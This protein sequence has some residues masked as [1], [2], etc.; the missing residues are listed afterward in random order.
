MTDWTDFTGRLER[1]SV[2]EKAV[3]EKAFTMGNKAHEGQQRQSGEPYFSHPIAVA[4]ILIDMGADRDTIVAALLHDTV[5]DTP[6]TLKDIERAFGSDVAVLID[7][8][9]KLEQTDLPADRQASGKPKLDEQIE[10]LRKMFTL[11]QQDVR[12][13]VIKLADRLHN[14][15][16]IGFRPL[17]KQMTVARE[18]MDIY[19]KIA[20]RLGMRDMQD[21]L[22]SL[23]LAVLEPEL[24]ARLQELRHARQEQGQ[25]SLHAVD[26]QLRANHP[27]ITKNV[28]VLYEHKTWSRLRQQLE[29]NGMYVTGLA[30]VAAAIVCDTEDTCY[31]MMG[32]LHHDWQRETL[33]FQDFI[34]SPMING[35]R[36]LHT[37]IITEDGIR[38][39]CKIRTRDMQEYAHRGITM[40]CFDQKPQ[41]PMEYLPWTQRI[42]TIST[43]TSDR[44]AEFWEGL[45]SDIL[46]E[47]ILVHGPNDSTVLVPRDATVLDGA[48]FLLREHAHTLSHIR[49]N[50]RDVTFATPL[51]HAAT[52]EIE[53]T[54]RQAVQH[55]WLHIVKTGLAAALIRRGLSLQ[56]REQKI[57]VGSDLLEDHL[58]DTRRVF[59]EE[60]QSETVN[61]LLK[62]SDLPPLEETAILIAEGR[63]TPEEVSDRLFNRNSSPAAVRARSIRSVVTC[64]IRRMDRNTLLGMLESYMVEHTHLQTKHDGDTIHCRFTVRLNET[65]RRTLK[66][67]FEN[68]LH[69]PYTIRSVKSP[70]IMTT[71]TILLFL[72]WGLD[73]VFAHILLR[74]PTLSAIDLHA[75]RFLS[76]TVLS[77][78]GLLYQHRRQIIPEARLPLRSASLWISVAFLMLVS[79]TSY[80]SL[81]TTSPSHYT[82]PMTAA[83]LL[84]TSIV[85]RRHIATLAGVWTTFIAGIALLLMFSPSW[86]G[87]DMFWTALAVISFAGFS[88]VS[89]RYK[90][91]EHVSLRVSQYFFILSALCLALSAPLLFFS[92]L[93]DINAQTLGLSILFCILCTALPY[94]IYYSLLS[95]REIDFVLRFS[96][97]IIPLTILCQALLTSV[98][99]W[100]T[101][102]AALIVMAGAALPPLAFTQREKLTPPIANAMAQ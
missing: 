9:T 14:M 66:G 95:H 87:M 56:E 92:T 48:Y 99:S 23:C 27:E 90:R 98:P 20:D 46:G 50:G 63:I 21:T 67:F 100:T 35:Y 26:L 68:V 74:D 10:T 37:T 102:I 30:T 15:Q 89:E 62:A 86:V 41:G 29:S 54:P 43:D 11:M 7:G 57:R 73:P 31:R 76:L 38:V 33:S 5:E 25:K 36:A 45:Q 40:F 70:F 3:I 93:H 8:V 71:A 85:H 82:I 6:L 4:R 83:G 59:L 1:F 28:S 12:I 78:L 24:H 53:L 88:L 79:I 17:E 32:A 44:S 55:Q 52:L 13:M 58:K 16:T 72:L 51:E 77:G 49:M 19:A 69:C 34:N 2:S 84:L 101:L 39:R 64:R 97:L 61:Q 47:T 94:I 80:M 18:T 60:L 22:E 65:E 42:A 96:F 75:I 81:V 91:M